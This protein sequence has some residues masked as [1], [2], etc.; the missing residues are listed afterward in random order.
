M[1]FEEFREYSYED[2]LNIADHLQSQVREWISV[3]E[4]LP[5]VKTDV[6]VAERWVDIPFVGY[7]VFDD[8]NKITWRANKEFYE[9]DGDAI[10]IDT[11]E[12]A[13]VT[14]WQPLPSP[15]KEET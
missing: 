15:P 1:K 7:L 6:L 11:V 9:A 3:D 2:L 14:H 4:R 13:D 8:N 10:L 5:E 12:S